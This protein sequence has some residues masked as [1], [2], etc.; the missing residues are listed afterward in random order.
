MRRSSAPT[1]SAATTRPPGAVFTSL[2]STAKSK[3]KAASLR[4][5]RHGAG[6]YTSAVCL[7]E[8]R[9]CDDIQRR[10]AGTIARSTARY[11]AAVCDELGSWSPPDVGHV[12]VRVETG[13]KPELS[14]CDGNSADKADRR[15]TGPRGPRRRRDARFDLRKSRKPGARIFSTK[16]FANTRETRLGATGLDAELLEDTPC[17][18]CSHGIERVGSAPFQSSP[19]SWWRSPPRDLRGEADETG[20]VLVGK[21]AKDHGHVL[22]DCRQIF[23]DRVSQNR[24]HRLSAHHSDRVVAERN[25]CGDMVEAT[26]RMVDQNLPVTTVWASRGKVTRAEPV[27]A[28]YEQG[29]T[30]SAQSRSSRIK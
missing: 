2:L 7:A 25:N 10:G 19:E 16:S 27:S 28:L 26:I 13:A 11:D 29:R 6:R 15:I 8:W 4:S 23:T 18:L 22:A 12:A 3:E 21:D 20:I 30:M 9:H 5:R 14:R 1:L 24:H 17:A